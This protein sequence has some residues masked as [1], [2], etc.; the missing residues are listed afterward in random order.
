MAAALK[1]AES[2]GTLAAGRPYPSRWRRCSRTC[3]RTC[4]RTCASR[5]GRRHAHEGTSK[6]RGGRHGHADDHDPGP[7]LGDGRAAG[8]DP[9]VVVFGE[10]VGYFGGVFRCTEGLQ[11]KYGKHRVFDSPIAEGGIVGTAMGM[12]ANG[13]QARG[14]D[15]VRRLLLPRFGPDRLRGGPAALPFGGRLH[16]AGG[17]PHALRRRH[18]WRADAQPEPRGAVHPCLRAAHGDAQQPL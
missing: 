16:G 10:D 18:L 9:N 14:G 11:A 6:H 12:A 15:P 4:R 7:A 2:Y 13:L 17:H 5:C 8:R 1:E 3:T